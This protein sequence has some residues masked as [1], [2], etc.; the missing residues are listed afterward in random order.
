MTDYIKS[1]FGLI[2][3]SL[4]ILAYVIDCFRHKKTPEIGKLITSAGSGIGIEAGIIFLLGG[5]HPDPAEV[6]GMFKGRQITLYVIS[7][8]LFHYSGTNL[9]N[10]FRPEK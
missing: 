3:A 7:I 2:L 8:M 4:F 5:F 6:L 10:C 9:V 1:K